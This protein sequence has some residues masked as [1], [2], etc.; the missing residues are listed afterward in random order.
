MVDVG[1]GMERWWSLEVR[2]ERISVKILGSG[3]AGMGEVG[4]VEEIGALSEVEGADV[5]I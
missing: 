4:E 3:F 1:L 2:V 5:A